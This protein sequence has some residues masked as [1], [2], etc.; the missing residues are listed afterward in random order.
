V[1]IASGG[2]RGIR[3]AITRA[4]AQERAVPVIRECDTAAAE[5]LCAEFCDGSL[6]TSFQIDPCSATGRAAAIEGTLCVTNRADALV[7]NSGVNASVSLEKGGPEEFAALLRRNLLHYYNIA[8][9]AL[10]SLKSARRAFL[11]IASKVAFTARSGLSGCAASKGTIVALTKEWAARLLPGGARVTRAV[12]AEVMTP[13]YRQRARH[14][15]KPQRETRGYRCEDPA[16]LANDHGR[17]NCGN[18]GIFGFRQI[19]A[20]SR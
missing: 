14:L 13:L 16:G 10:P 17:G 1:V 6:S 20:Y 11:N 4:L 18:D 12:P 15:S 2:A 3:T 8:H 19:S 9:D 5:S 7:N